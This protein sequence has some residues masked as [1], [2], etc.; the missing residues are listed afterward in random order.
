MAVAPAGAAA[1][2]RASTAATRDTT[3]ADLRNCATSYRY[4]ITV[5][6]FNRPTRMREQGDFEARYLPQDPSPQY[7]VEAPSSFSRY[8]KA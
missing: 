4:Q 5:I 3:N 8:S 6:Y 1:K 2:V 7:L